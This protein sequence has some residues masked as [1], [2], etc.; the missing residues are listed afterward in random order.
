MPTGGHAVADDEIDASGLR[1]AIV[2]SSFNGD[3]TRK[4]LEGCADE[5]RERGASGDAVAVHNVPGCFELPLMAQTLAA[6]GGFDAII[7]LG[8]IIR[9][10]T[11]H[12][13]YVSSATASGVLRVGLDTGVPAIFGVLTVDNEQ[14]AYE[15]VG[16]AAGHKGRE[17]A[18]TA[19]AMTRA[20]GAARSMEA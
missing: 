6:R 1:F 3:V 15:R 13:E 11:P 19:I 7:C 10:D 4:L 20:L 2:V 14:Q 9:G 5:L 16:G 17:A 12:F 8:A 18:L